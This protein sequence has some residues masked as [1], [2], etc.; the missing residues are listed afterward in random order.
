MQKN[1]NISTNSFGEKLCTNK[2]RNGHMDRVYFTGP[3][4]CW[5]SNTN[6]CHNSKYLFFIY[7]FQLDV[8]NKVKKT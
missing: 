4:V 2:E 8:I 6:I 5:P 7:T 1:Q 3:S